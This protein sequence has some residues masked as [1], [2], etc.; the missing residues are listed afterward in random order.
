MVFI[1]KLNLVIFNTMQD[2]ECFLSVTDLA[3]TEG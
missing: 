1:L 2:P 3:L